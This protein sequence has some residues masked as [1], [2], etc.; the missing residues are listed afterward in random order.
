MI[1]HCHTSPQTRAA[2]MSHRSTYFP[3][4]RGTNNSVQELS[5]ISGPQLPPLHVNMVPLPRP[6]QNEG[7]SSNVC[8]R[9]RS[10]RTP[11]ASCR[12]P[13]ASCRTPDASCRSRHAHAN[14]GNTLICEMR[15]CEGRWGNVESSITLM[16]N[17]GFVRKQASTIIV[18]FLGD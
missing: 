3:R 12:T 17:W 4:L 2:Q 9:N 18:S 16:R 5:S 6:E 14:G 11:D 13:D 10:C 7:E 1:L 8:P 15:G